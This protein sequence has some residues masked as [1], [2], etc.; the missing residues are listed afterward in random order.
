[1]AATWP[2]SPTSRSAP[3]S[4]RHPRKLSAK[5]SLRRRPGLN[6]PGSVETQSL[7]LGTGQRRP[8]PRIG[9]P[10]GRDNVSKVPQASDCFGTILV[11][12]ELDQSRRVEVEGHRRRSRTSS[13]TLPVLLTL[14]ISRA[15]RRGVD[16]SWT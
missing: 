2:T 13:D 12:E 16:G 5:C 14:L 10:A 15:G 1:M 6:P 4:E 9:E 3:R 7:N 11:H 8:G